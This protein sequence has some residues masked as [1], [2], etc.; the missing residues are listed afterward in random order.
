MSSLALMRHLPQQGRPLLSFAAVWL[1]NSSPDHSLGP[2]FV[3]STRVSLSS[4]TDQHWVVWDWKQT[5]H[6]DTFSTLTPLFSILQE[7]S[8]GRS[9]SN[10]GKPGIVAR[11]ATRPISNKACYSENALRAMWSCLRLTPL[12]QRSN[13]FLSEDSRTDRSQPKCCPRC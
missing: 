1:W 2:T 11:L 9:R 5:R 4:S 6:N 7:L 12:P 13:W 10:H 3:H 8:E